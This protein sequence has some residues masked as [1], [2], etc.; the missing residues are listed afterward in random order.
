[1]IEEDPTS[2]IKVCKKDIANRFRPEIH[3]EL[4]SS[5]DFL[6]IG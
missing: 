3:F 6:I 1:M 5:P 2:Q 4:L